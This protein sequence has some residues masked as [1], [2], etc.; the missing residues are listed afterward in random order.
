MLKDRRNAVGLGPIW[1]G[2]LWLGLTTTLGQAVGQL[3]SGPV[4]M[5]E[6]RVGSELPSLPVPAAKCS[7]FSSA[8]VSPDH[9]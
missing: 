3:D 9:R 4:L 6:R 7:V 2:Q 1:Q 8:V 5:S